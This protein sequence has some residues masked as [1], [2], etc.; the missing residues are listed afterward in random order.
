MFLKINWTRTN[1]LNKANDATN[2]YLEK[3]INTFKDSVGSMIIKDNLSEYDIE[4]NHHARFCNKLNKL[5]IDRNEYTS[6]VSVVT[7]LTNTLQSLAT[8][9]CF[10]FKLDIEVY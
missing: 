10:A 9:V 8:Q 5:F 6:Q 2:T 3:F 4:I 7:Q 1:G